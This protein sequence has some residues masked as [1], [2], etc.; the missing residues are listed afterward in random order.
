MTVDELSSTTYRYISTIGVVG[1][2]YM[3]SAPVP[4]FWKAAEVRVSTSPT[5]E[6]AVIAPPMIPLAE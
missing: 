6:Q 1:S 2:V 4:G 3:I 5:V